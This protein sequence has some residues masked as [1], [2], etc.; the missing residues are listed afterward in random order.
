[1]KLMVSIYLSTS[2]RAIHKEALISNGGLL[3]TSWKEGASVWIDEDGTKSE[4]MGVI[5]PIYDN[6]SPRHPVYRNGNRILKHHCDSK[7][8]Y[9]YL[10]NSE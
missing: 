4:Q 7:T 1:M 10:T 6:Q 5:Y 8:V 3:Q 9:R 2:I